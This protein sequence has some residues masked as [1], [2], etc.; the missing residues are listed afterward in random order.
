MLLRTVSAG[1]AGSIFSQMN[2]NVAKVQITCKDVLRMTAIYLL[3]PSD[4]R[5]H[6]MSSYQEQ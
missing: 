6:S 5:Y 1:G 4:R 2:K 3:Q